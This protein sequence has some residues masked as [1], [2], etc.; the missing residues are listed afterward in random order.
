MAAGNYLGFLRDKQGPMVAQVQLCRSSSA[1]LVLLVLGPVVLVRLVLHEQ[2]SHKVALAF[3]GLGFT[4][5]S[6]SSSP[7][8]EPLNHHKQH[9]VPQAALKRHFLSR[10]LQSFS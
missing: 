1:D 6:N 3:A 2:S 8:V 5:N 10:E 7:S 4:N 9:L